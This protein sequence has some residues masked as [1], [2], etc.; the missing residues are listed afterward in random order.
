LRGVLSSTTEENVLSG[1]NMMCV[2][3]EYIAF[4]DATL[5]PD[6]S[7]TL[8]NLLRGLRGT[9]WAISTHGPND[10]VIMSL[11]GTYPIGLMEIIDLNLSETFAAVDI[12]GTLNS[13]FK[14]SIVYHGRAKMPYAPANVTGTQGS[15]PDDWT[16]EWDRRTRVGGIVGWQAN[17]LPVSETILEF[18]VDV[19]DGDTVVRTITSTASANGSVVSPLLDTALYTEDDQVLDF[20]SPQ[21]TVSIVVYQMSELVGRGF[22]RAATLEA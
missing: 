15:A 11:G 6:T 4:A 22:G 19:L 5:N 21:T 20:G 18:E 17:P 10:R 7:Y 3:N 2:G 9:E 8:T 1:A 14:Q 16:F 12:G 13:A